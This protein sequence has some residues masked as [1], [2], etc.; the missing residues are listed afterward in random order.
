MTASIAEIERIIGT[1]CTE[2]LIVAYGGR[3]LYVP[4]RVRVDHPLALRLGTGP[5][6]LLAQA[7]G[8]DYIELPTRRQRDIRARNLAIRAE[9][10]AGASQAALASLYGLTVR[11]I[12]NITREEPDHV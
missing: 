3:R 4:E 9:Y 6:T 12:R 1:E 11:Q 5:A 2:E 10:A 7:F 8:G